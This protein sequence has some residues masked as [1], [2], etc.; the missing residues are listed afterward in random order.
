MQTAA[1]RKLFKRHP[2]PACT[3]IY[4]QKTIAE[5]R[6]EYLIPFTPKYCPKC[7]RRLD[8]GK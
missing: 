2:C 3:A 4:Y 1:I 5:D 6:R 7:G 8:S